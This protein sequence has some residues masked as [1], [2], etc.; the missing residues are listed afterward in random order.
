M[1]LLFLLIR[2][3][4]ATREF[5]KSGGERIPAVEAAFECQAFQVHLIDKPIMHELFA[6]S[7][8][9]LVQIIIK[10]QT[11]LPVDKG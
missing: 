4:R 5:F 1:G 7:Y 3:R 11:E 8:P 9:E 6:I 2:G 10:F